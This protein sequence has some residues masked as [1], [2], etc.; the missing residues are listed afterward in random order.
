M[1]RISISRPGGYDRLVCEEAPD[2]VPGPGEVLLAVEAVGVNY[3][4]CVIRMGLY[5]SAKKYVGWPITPG[6]E[7]AGRVAAVGAGVE[8]WPVGARA[9]VVTRFGGYASH[10]VVPAHQVFPLPEGWSPVEAACLPTV[11]LTAWYAFVRCAAVEAG[12]TILVHSA[13]GGVGGALL[14]I[15][16]LTGVRAIG[17]VGG[18]HKVA[19]ARSLGADAV[20]DTSTEAL[21]P[22]VER[23]APDGFHA[24]FDANGIST[25]RES[26]RHLRPTGRLVVYGHHSML[27]R[28]RGR[29]NWP[30]LAWKALRVP[31]FDPLR[32]TEENKSV[33]A[34]NLSYLFEEEALLVRAMGQ[35]LAWAGAGTITPPPVRTWPLREAAEAHRALET[36]TTTGK[37]ALLVDADEG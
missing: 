37:L 22:T 8:D 28:K 21:W 7:A 26:Y 17:V 12:Q 20:I 23:L 4:D 11:F 31:R 24:V 16:R 15:A 34:F 27:P 10:V 5:S 1:Q 2:P 19:L 35:V 9:L 36:G 32:M 3:A 13:A 29:P 30:V 25:L 14:Q 18:S 33:M 6:F